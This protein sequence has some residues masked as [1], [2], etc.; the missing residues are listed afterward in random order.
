MTGARMLF[1]D[2]LWSSELFARLTSI[3]KAS[4]SAQFETLPALLAE[5][6]YLSH[7]SG[8]WWEGN[9]KRGGFTH[10]M[11]RGFSNEQNSALKEE[12]S[13]YNYSS[14]QDGRLI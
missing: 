14:S 1:T 13:Y 4:I 12:E 10:G 6:G 11:T 2:T 9:Y 8:K 3:S 5:R 7:Q